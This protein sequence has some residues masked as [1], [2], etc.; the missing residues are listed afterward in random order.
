MFG[1]A[2]L[3]TIA[4]VSNGVVTLKVPTLSHGT[5]Q[6]HIHTTDQVVVKRVVKK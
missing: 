3:S 1:Q 5:Y 6:A 2:V 4:K